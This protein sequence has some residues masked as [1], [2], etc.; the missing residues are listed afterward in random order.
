[1]EDTMRVIAIAASLA[2]LAAAPAVA[3]MGN[4]AGMTPAT[5]QSGPGT[6]APNQPNTQDRL[7]IELLATGGMAE[8]D[9]A[10]AAEA[11]AQSPAVKAF[12]RRM[13]QDHARANDELAR[14]AKQDN[15]PLPRDLDHDHKATRDY[16]GKLSGAQF[17]LA[18]LQSQLVDHQKTVQ[19]LQ[20][21]MGSGQDAELQRYAS[22]QL[23]IVLQHLETVQTLISQTTGAAP[24]GLA[25][26]APT[27]SSATVAAR[28]PRADASQ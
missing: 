16:L 14:L 19:I 24:Q 1:M 18:Y 20:W 26:S 28:E 5:P 3:Q 10:K 8:L 2:V 17:D 21:E 13:A 9:S 11:K 12:A 23:P 22:A 4:P 6:P 15:V 25:S 7:F 27:P